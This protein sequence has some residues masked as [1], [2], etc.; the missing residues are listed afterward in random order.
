MSKNNGIVVAVDASRNRSGGAKAHLIG[1]LSDFE[2]KPCIEEIHVWT[3]REL[4]DALPSY[5]FL[6][7]HIP[8]ELNKNI[9]TQ[10]FWQRYKL[11]L[12]L[13]D[14]NVDI[15]LSTD[16]T[17]VCNFKPSIVMSRDML[18]FEKG[19]MARYF[20]SMSWLRLFLIKYLQILSLRSATG[21]IFLTKYAQDA[22]SEFTGKIEQSRVIPHGV[23]NS[24][25]GSPRS[26]CDVEAP[27]F[28]YVSNADA[29]KHQWHVID[30]FYKFRRQ[31]GKDA[32]LT[33]IG[34]LSG[35]CANKV[36][37]AM[38]QHDDGSNSVN[39]TELISH[40]EISKKLSSHDIFIF[41]SSCENMPNTLIEGM[42][43]GLPVICSNRGPMPEVLTSQGVFFDP[44]DP[45]SIKDSMITITSDV[46]LANDKARLSYEIADN[47]SWKRCSKETFEYL[48]SVHQKLAIEE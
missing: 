18:S 33:L 46:I 2:K 4:A 6:K 28:I 44:E 45:C 47:F 35:S 29:Y 15:L 39:A 38:K 1:I 40:P 14:C 11:P 32:S 37:H 41:A 13:K 22:I 25:R 12:E 8:I 36:V 27:K 34:A 42:S 17:T 19:E 26:M 24:F 43:S 3:Y 21:V 20:P 10:L 48:V 7:I 5:P 16:A 9:L 30:A 23:S 31:T